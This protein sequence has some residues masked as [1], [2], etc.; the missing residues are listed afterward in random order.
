M[1]TLH[2]VQS[3][4]FTTS[5]TWGLVDTSSAVLTYTTQGFPL[6]TPT[7]SPTF[8]PGV[9]TVQGISIH[10]SNR[11]TSATG[12]ITV[13]LFNATTAIVVAS[14]TINVTDLF[15]NGGQGSSPIGWVYFKFTSPVTTVTAQLYSVRL[16]NS[17]G[18]QVAVNYL[19]TA[20][21]WTKVL[22]TT[23]N[24]APAATDVLVIAGEHTAAGVSSTYSVTM[25]NTNTT[26]FGNLFVSS[27]GTLIY[28]TASSTNYVLRLAGNLLVQYFGTLQIGS[29]SDPIPAT[30]T[31]TLE[32]LCTTALQFTIIVFGT[33]TTYGTTK[34]IA[35][36]LAADVAIGATTSTTSTATGWLNG[37]II[38]VPST[39]RTSTQ[40]E[41]KTLN[42]NASGTTLTH[43]AYTFA[44]GGNATTKVQADVVN[45]TRNVIIRS[46]TGTLLTNK[47][48]IQ[49]KDPSIT[50]FFYTAFLALGTSTTTTTSGICVAAL[51]TGTITAQ[52]GS[53]DFQYNVVREI[54]TQAATTTAAC[55]F[56]TVSNTG[57]NISNNIFYLLGWSTI[58]G[59]TILTSINDNNYFMGC[60]ATTQII[61][62]SIAG[63]GIVF[64]SN[65]TPAAI[66]TFYNN[67]SNC[68]FYSNNT[69][70]LYMT[71]VVGV[72]VSNF[73]FW[74]NNTYGIQ[75]IQTTPYNRNNILLFDGCY[76]F[77]NT[78][79]SINYIGAPIRTKIYFTN[80]FFYGGTTLVQP[81]HFANTIANPAID[82]FYY[83]NCYF[84]YS[85][86]SLTSSP[87]S[88]SALS[89]PYASVYKIFNNCY[90]NTI[91]T[92]TTAQTGY[93]IFGG[94]RSLNHN[95]VTASNREWN[96]NGLITTDPTIFL[97]S[98]K[99][100]RLTPNSATIKLT[101]HLVRVPVKIGTTCTISVNVRESITADGAVYNG[102]APRLMYVFNPILGN[103]TE[104]IAKIPVNLFQYPQNFDNAYWSKFASSIT[105]DSLS[106]AA[107]DS[108][109]TADL[110][111][112]D[113]TTTR[114]RILLQGTITVSIGTTYN[115]SVYAKKAT[116]DW[117]QLNPV[118]DSFFGG[119][120]WANFNLSTGTIG[121][122]GVGVGASIESVGNGWYRLSLQCDVIA[123]GVT[124][125]NLFVST[126]NT[127][128]AR[129]PS[130]LGTN[131]Q[132]FYIW[133]A[134]LT[135]G[136]ELLPYYDNGQ[137]EKLTYTTATFSNDGV[138]EFYVDCDGTAGW[139]NIDDWNTTTA[140]DS[141]GQ[142]Y[143]GANGV[144]IEPNY[145][146][147]G[148][149][150]TFTT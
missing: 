102:N 27:K 3:G 147:P 85:D 98:N 125:F 140:N 109:F 129:Y 96:Q 1:A 91:E 20:Q 18:N 77:G 110:F 75:F 103:N 19:T 23:T 57:I 130:Y 54:V 35:T 4:N 37:D 134:Q 55:A 16:T 67:S 9:I 24:Q 97:S 51:N 146:Q 138:A 17:G 56:Q 126:N 133:G 2:S 38:A 132:C 119:N 101:S 115:L 117:I 43:N 59:T 142:D 28:G 63:G 122:T 124:F 42:T 70:G 71:S 139:V 25:N 150:S 141:R 120:N 149:S 31:A 135:E 58:V 116:H 137:W 114:H 14:V 15:N 82:T 66:T 81:Q 40:H 84:G 111:S 87:F 45:L 30:S 107:P 32:I 144:Y 76:F 131:A 99:S 108:T 95:G 112:E 7:A 49:M 73:L 94:F 68:S 10:I 143:W 47:T 86:T 52:T 12:T 44:H 46:A 88:T 48:N 61:N 69:I 80:S 100:I 36:K 72:S 148:G 65:N 39:T 79:T 60:L 62:A 29:V 13:E 136:P 105:P 127:N 106:V 89:A 8:T 26:A 145:K 11:S 128:S 41:T 92:T 118:Y 21:N 50:S 93:N 123:S 53:F 34:T 6:T 33:M 78:L 83:S 64:A 90:F 74:R 22:V 5:T 104:T 121:N 113:A